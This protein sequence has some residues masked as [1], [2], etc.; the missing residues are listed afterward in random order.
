MSTG[1][2]F[3]GH[4]LCPLVDTFYVH[5]GHNLCPLAPGT[6][7]RDND[8]QR[9]KDTLKDTKDREPLRELEE[10]SVKV[11]TK[12]T[13]RC[14][15]TAEKETLDTDSTIHHFRDRRR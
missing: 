9:P 6:S 12:S 15:R 7:M 5:L 13:G 1:G 14:K 11:F 2:R 8:L 4:V 3:S 10:P